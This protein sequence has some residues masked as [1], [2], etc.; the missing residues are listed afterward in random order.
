MEMDWEV[1]LAREQNE[2]AI[3]GENQ[4]QQLELDSKVQMANFAKRN[5]RKIERSLPQPIEPLSK[6]SEV[7]FNVLEDEMLYEPNGSESVHVEA[8]LRK[9]PKPGLEMSQFEGD[10]EREVA[11]KETKIMRLEQRIEEPDN[12]EIL[13]ENRSIQTKANEY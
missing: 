3:Q 12:C 9:R 13:Y 2:C 6:W 8:S 7:A 1:T 10:N 5:N 4:H 11:I